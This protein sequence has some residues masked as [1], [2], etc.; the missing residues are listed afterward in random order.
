MLCFEL[1][2]P[3]VALADVPEFWWAGRQA[4][5]SRNYGESSRRLVRTGLL[6]PRRVAS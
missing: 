6:E 2:K 1:E 3:G 5:K 4:G